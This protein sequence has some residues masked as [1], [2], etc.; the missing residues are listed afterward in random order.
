MFTGTGKLV[1][2][3]G[4]LIDSMEVATMGKLEAEL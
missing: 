2:K 4:K 3:T 1:E